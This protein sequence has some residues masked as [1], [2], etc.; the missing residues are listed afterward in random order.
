MLDLC[1]PLLKRNARVT[2]HLRISGEV[3][4]E[5]HGEPLGRA[6][7]R[8]IAPAGP[9]LQQVRHD[10][11]SRDLAL[12]LVDDVARS[13]SRGENPEPAGEFERYAGLADGRYFRQR[14]RARR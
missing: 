9:A 11:R 5:F 12:Q 10:D 2:Y 3:G 7:D 4:F 14:R 1:A 8:F 6:A 13:M